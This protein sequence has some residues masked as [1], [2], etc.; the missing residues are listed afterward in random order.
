MKN[1]LVLMMLLLCSSKSL[2]QIHKALDG[3]VINCNIVTPG[4][5]EQ[6][7][8]DKA[9]R[10]QI[11]EQT[12]LEDVAEATIQV[13]LVE[14]PCKGQS[15]D[16]AP[17]TFDGVIVENYTLTVSTSEGQL[18]FKQSLDELI[19]QSTET[20]TFG[21]PAIF[22]KSRIPLEIGIQ[23]TGKVSTNREMF[24]PYQANFGVFIFKF[25]QEN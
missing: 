24:N 13:K 5:A 21:V 14:D 15:L 7:K 18:L 23:L 8:Y 22:A 19:N 12:I 6:A 3:H 17:R 9:L 2:S 25:D 1:L 11:L 20:L 4:Q 10:L 16:P